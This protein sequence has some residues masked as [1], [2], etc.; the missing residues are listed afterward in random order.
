[1]PKDLVEG[2]EWFEGD[3]VEFYDI[4]IGTTSLNAT[5]AAPLCNGDLVTLMVTVRLG[6]PKFSRIRKTGELKRTNPAVVESCIVFDPEHAKFVYD[7][8]G[9]KVEGINEGLLEVPKPGIQEESF[10]I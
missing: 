5:D 6:D 4:R 8:L 10:D 9:K 1:M 7:N 2:R 3:P